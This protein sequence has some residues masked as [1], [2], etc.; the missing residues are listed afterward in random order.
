MRSSRRKELL[1]IF[2]LAFVCGALVGGVFVFAN[3]V[4]KNRL[5]VE[6]VS[7]VNGHLYITLVNP[8]EK[9]FRN[10]DIYLNDVKI[11]GIDEFL[12]QSTQSVEV[13]S[14]VL[15]FLERK[16]LL[17]IELKSEGRHISSENFKIVRSYSWPEFAL[18]RIPI[19]VYVNRDVENYYLRIPIQLPKGVTSYDISFKVL[20]DANREYPSAWYPV[21]DEEGILVVFLKNL[22]RNEVIKLYAYANSSKSSVSQITLPDLRDE[23]LVEDNGTLYCLKD[24]ELSVINL[25]TPG[26]ILG[27][28]L[29]DYNNDGILDGIVAVGTPEGGAIYYLGGKDRCSFSDI[30]KIGK[31]SEGYVDILSLDING[32]GFLDVVYNDGDKLVVLKNKH[33]YFEKV[34]ELNVGCT[35]GKTAVDWNSDDCLDILF[36]SCGDGHLFVTYGDCNFHFMDKEFVADVQEDGVYREDMAESGQPDEVTIISAKDIDRDGGLEIVLVNSLEGA[37]I[38]KDNFA[39]VSRIYGL[40]EIEDGLKFGGMYDYNED[41]NLDLLLTLGG[42]RKKICVGDLCSVFYSFIPLEDSEPLKGIYIC[43]GEKFEKCN[44]IKDTGQIIA[45][46]LWNPLDVEVGASQELKITFERVG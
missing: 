2:L 15:S 28:S 39:N 1:K 37:W 18:F 42:Y 43:Y 29:A 33:G 13:R 16:N 14:N 46:P 6:K 24:G 17:T 32:D 26:E 4:S 25:P 22:A 30:Q 40:D 7:Y 3:Y 20:T 45:V 8:T 10:V 19:T 34:D 21:S 12:P 31:V 27:I 35:L 5:F 38:V 11:G 44:K 23:Y 9:V 41:S 36:A